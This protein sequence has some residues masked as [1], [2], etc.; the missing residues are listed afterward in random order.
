MDEA[1]APEYTFQLDAPMGGGTMGVR[2]GGSPT[3][4][5]SGRKGGTGTGTGGGG[6]PADSQGTGRKVSAASIASAPAAVGD[7]S[8][9]NWKDYPEEALRLGVEGPVLVK[10]FVDEQGRVTQVTLIKGPGH[11][12]NE[13]GLALARKIRFEPAV[14]TD[15]TKA[16]YPVTWTWNFELPR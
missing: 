13:A 11:G 5:L 16:A 4:S 14:M 7:Y 2:S 9:D 12:L 15:G 1:P 10:I 8:L 6:G 3:G